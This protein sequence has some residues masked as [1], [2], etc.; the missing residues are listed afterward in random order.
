[1]SA[2]TMEE[3]SA[4]PSPSHSQHANA[5]NHDPLAQLQADDESSPSSPSNSPPQPAAD[6]D[7]D[8]EEEYEPDAGQHRTPL[9]PPSPSSP[10]VPS[11]PL[12]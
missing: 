12:R 11:S 2:A 10:L 4:A 8:S 9:S 5:S 3:D 1:M 6:D 7:D